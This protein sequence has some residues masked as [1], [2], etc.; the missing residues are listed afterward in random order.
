MSFNGKVKRRH[1]KKG[2]SKAFLVVENYRR[3][4]NGKSAN[5][6]VLYF[7]TLG[8]NK[9]INK[10]TCQKFWAA[11]ERKIDAAVL[12]QII[13][14]DEVEKV[15]DKLK[16]DLGVPTTPVAS[17]ETWNKVKVKYSA[18]LDE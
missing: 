15:K 14:A 1:G 5:R 6:D 13:P 10:L 16:R 7:G 3:K 12:K 11:A 18:L 9:W 2:I 4:D 17:S 8:Y